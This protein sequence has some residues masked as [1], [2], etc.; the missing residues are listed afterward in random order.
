MA[1]NHTLILIYGRDVRKSSVYKKK[2]KK[3][4]LQL[5]IFNT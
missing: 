2:K 1:V 5:L 3:K 4:K